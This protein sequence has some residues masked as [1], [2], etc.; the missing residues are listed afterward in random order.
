MNENSGYREGHR[1]LRRGTGMDQPWILASDVDN[2]LTGDRQALER[3]REQVRKLRQQEKLVLFLST[4]RRLV[5]VLDGFEKESI[6]KADAIISQVGT[7]I[8]LPPFSPD[9]SPLPEWNDRLHQQ[10]SRERA[11]EFLQGIE[12]LEMQ[13]GKYNTSLKVSCYLDKTPDPEKAATRI[14]QR[15]VEAGESDTYQVVWSSGRDLDIIPAAA[16]KGKAIHYLIG[17]LQLSPKE[18]IVAGDSGNDRTMFDE[19]SHGIVVANAQPELEKL[20]KEDE[21]PQSAVYFA[22]NSFAAGVEEGLRHFGV[23]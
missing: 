20:E 23:F 2:T 17:F 8:Y 5:Q 15:V 1:Y 13:P 14:K 12:G 19:F 6:P 4:G 21:D 3:L 9:M 7:E 10:F 16:G 11:V 18:V 22:H